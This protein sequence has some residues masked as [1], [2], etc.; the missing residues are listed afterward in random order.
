MSQPPEKY[1]AEDELHGRTE[2]LAAGRLREFVLFMKN[3]GPYQ[4]TAVSRAISRTLKWLD[5]HGPTATTEHLY[6]RDKLEYVIEYDCSPSDDEA[7]HYK[8]DDE[9][10]DDEESDK[11][12]HYY[13][14]DSESHG[15]EADSGPALTLPL[16]RAAVVEVPSQTLAGP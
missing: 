8:S 11:A 4:Q 7:E 6:K 2:S 5:A 1:S 14:S 9:E 12:K 10:S 15:A 3:S 13:E 16:S